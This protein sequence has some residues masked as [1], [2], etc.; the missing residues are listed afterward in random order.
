MHFCNS[1]SKMNINVYI[2]DPCN[3]WNCRLCRFYY[4]VIFNGKYSV[5]I[6]GG[7][8]PPKA[9]SPKASLVYSDLR[10][11]RDRPGGEHSPNNSLKAQ[12]KQHQ[13]RLK[14]NTDFSFL[15]MSLIK[16]Q[17]SH[18]TQASLYFIHSHSW[19]C[20]FPCWCGPVLFLFANMKW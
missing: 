15:V 7:G 2:N 5:H 14:Q 16:R 11:E 3:T 9:L 8:S 4:H 17:H 12:M 18:L 10:H 19:W 6:L 20:H 13:K 1:I